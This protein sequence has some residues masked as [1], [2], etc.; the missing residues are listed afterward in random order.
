MEIW[1][2]N[3]WRGLCNE[4]PLIAYPDKLVE[5]AF[6]YEI[7]AGLV[8]CIEALV[9]P[10]GGDF[11]VKLEDQVLVTEKGYENLSKY[12]FDERLMGKM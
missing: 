12:P 9:S 8:L 10:D 5:G 3:A 2:F 6:D 1:L 7:Q 11:S 4:W